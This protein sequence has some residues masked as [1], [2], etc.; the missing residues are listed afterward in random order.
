MPNYNIIS[1]FRCK[2]YAADPQRAN[3][4]V[5]PDKENVV[6]VPGN[7]ERNEPSSCHWDRSLAGL[8]VLFGE[9]MIYEH[10][11]GKTEKHRVAGYTLFKCGNVENVLVRVEDGM[12]EVK[13]MISAS[14]SRDRYFVLLSLDNSGKVS[15]GKCLCKAGATGKCKHVAAL[16][17]QLNEYKLMNKHEIPKQVAC[18]DEPRKWNVRKSKP[19]SISKAFDDLVL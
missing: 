4:I 14:Y 10:L 19:K 7:Q 12:F 8:P 18:T 6:Q 5:N 9:G 16:L 15:K 1:H 17:F 2:K 3:R 13:G 11:G